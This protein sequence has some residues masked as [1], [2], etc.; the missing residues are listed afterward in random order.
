MKVHNTRNTIEEYMDNPKAGTV[1]QGKD[2]QYA[3]SKREN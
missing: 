2:I 1:L 3:L